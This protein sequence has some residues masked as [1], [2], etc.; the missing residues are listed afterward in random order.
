MPEGDVIDNFDDIKMPDDI[1]E[2]SL[3]S[4]DIPPENGSL[5]DKILSVLKNKYVLIGIAVAV[6]VIIIAVVLALGTG[7]PSSPSPPQGNAQASPTSQEL[8]DLDADGIADL[9]DACPDTEPDI[10]VD[11][12]GCEK[13]EEE[14]SGDV[15]PSEPLIDIDLTKKD[16]EEL[17][18]EVADS[19]TFQISKGDNHTLSISSAT[20]DKATFE[21][22]SDPIKFTLAVGQFKEIDLDDDKKNDVNITLEDISQDKVVKFTIDKIVAVEPPA[23][24]KCTDTDSGK[25]EFIPGKTRDETD[26]VPDTCAEGSLIEYYCEGDTIQFETIECK[27]GCVVNETIGDSC[28]KWL[29]IASDSDVSDASDDK[30]VGKN[31]YVRGVCEGE[32]KGGGNGTDECRGEF[33]LREFFMYTKEGALKPTECHSL[34]KT[35]SYGCREGACLPEP[36][37]CGSLIW[38]M[39]Q[40]PQF[41]AGFAYVSEFP[42]G[43]DVKVGEI[44]YKGVKVSDKTN[45]RKYFYLQKGEEKITDMVEVG[46]AGEHKLFVEFSEEYAIHL[47]SAKDLEDGWT[48]IVLGDSDKDCI[49]N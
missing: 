30:K 7:K 5:F 4:S 26:L 11:E 17:E 19:K 21:I 44:T 33:Q 48:L 13:T 46:T 9:V 40:Y 16:S 36:V 43:E 6:V 27:N 35:C 1:N 29:E 42:N 45:I 31:Y 14:P 15:E 3:E 2:E 25:Y 23:I 41:E 22:S 20:A 38:N 37:A 28:R 12:T 34:F 24:A 47:I 18:L 10:E 49:S 32:L 8:A 39:R